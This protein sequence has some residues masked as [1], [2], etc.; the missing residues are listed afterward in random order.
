M[1]D[2]EKTN[3]DVEMEFYQCDNIPSYL[4]PTFISSIN[5]NLT[6]P[7]MLWSHKSLE[8]QG[9]GPVSPWNH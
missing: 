1:D 8:S 2:C 4:G 7:V 6:R 9:P 5:R 3:I